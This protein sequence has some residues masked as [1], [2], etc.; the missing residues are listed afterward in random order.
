MTLNPASL[1]QDI[2]DGIV[3]VIVCDEG[4]VGPE[5]ARGRGETVDIVV[6]EAP[7]AGPKRVG[8]AG[9]IADRIVSVGDVVIGAARTV[10]PTAFV[11]A[12][13]SSRFCAKHSIGLR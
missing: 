8:D 7:A 12:P 9:D 13:I 2:A 1:V 6:G 10:F 3:G 5:V 11:F 4:E